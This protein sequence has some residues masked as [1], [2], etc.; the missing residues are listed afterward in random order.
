MTRS[1]AF[2]WKSIWRVK[3]PSRVAF[4]TWRAAR[5]KILTMDNF[6]RMCKN[7]W[8]L[9]DHL[10]LHCSYAYNLGRNSTMHHV[11]YLARMES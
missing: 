10:L 9:A 7:S 6:R 1:H 5:G 3:V 8:E 11:D 4:F 2:T